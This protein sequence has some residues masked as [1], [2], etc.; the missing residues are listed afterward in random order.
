MRD[1]LD[2][3]DNQTISLQDIVSAIG[4]KDSN[5]SRKSQNCPTSTSNYRMISGSCFYFETSKKTHSDAKSN[6]QTKFGPGSPG[7][8]FEPRSSIMNQEVFNEATQLSS[9]GVKENLWLG[10]TNLRDNTVFE[11]E[12]DGQAVVSRMWEPSQPNDRNIHHCVT[13]YEG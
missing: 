3:A 8:L 5:G 2:L 12:S 9:I 7:R 6:C 1:L 13:M 11:Y 4:S 10:I